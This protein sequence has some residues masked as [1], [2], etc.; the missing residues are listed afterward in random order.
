LYGGNIKLP[1]KEKNSVI[2]LQITKESSATKLYSKPNKCIIDLNVNGKK[3]LNQTLKTQKSGSICSST[4]GNQEV[5][6]KIV[7]IQ[8]KNNKVVHLD[9]SKKLKINTNVNKENMNST[10]NIDPDSTKNK[11]NK[12]REKKKIVSAFNSILNITN[13]KSRNQQQQKKN[14]LENKTAENVTNKIFTTNKIDVNKT[15]DVKISNEANNTTL[16]NVITKIT[17]NKP[18]ETGISKTAMKAKQHPNI[19]SCLDREKKDNL[20]TSKT[21]IFKTKVENTNK[22]ISKNTFNISKKIDKN[23][24]RN[25]IIKITTTNSSTKNNSKPKLHSNFLNFSKNL[26]LVKKQ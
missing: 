19:I 15:K 6:Y 4:K 25:S 17:I 10:N 21:K 1:S 3:S 2:K 18:D 9:L 13:N 14:S 16:K 7:K 26:P 20:N 23:V 22:S 5:A 24:D 8:P 12:D 11:D